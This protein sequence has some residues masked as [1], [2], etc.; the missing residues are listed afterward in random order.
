MIAFLI[1]AHTD[2]EHVRRLA[3]SLQPHDVFVHVDAKTD[4]DN[5]W[6]DI[7]A[8]L[9]S[10]RTAVYWAGFSQVEAT[11]TLLDS[12]L[13]SGTTYD[14]IVLLSGADY[15]IK[16]MQELTKLF[17]ASPRLNFIKYVSM[18][19]AGHLPTL[20]DRTY[21]RDGILPWQLVKRFAFLRS[22]ERALRKLLE[23]AARPV[24]RKR[25]TRWKPMHG[26]AYW[27]ITH[28]CA[29]HLSSVADS[30]EGTKLKRYYRRTFASD[31][32]FFHTI[33]GNSRFSSESTGLIPYLGRGTYRAANL[34]IVDPSLSRWFAESD[35]N[36]IRASKMYFVRKVSTARSSSLIDI[37]DSPS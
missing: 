11:L 34:H 5:E 6:N 21:F 24:P 20:I 32:Q 33:I 17:D 10:H 9:V 28:E 2:P 26:S 8:T 23:L 1:L 4:L 30:K 25:L 15:P 19:G 29:I 22:V 7:P 14:R 36:E 31:E 12:A 18:D 37:L 16:P 13:K 35:I 27:A 3:L